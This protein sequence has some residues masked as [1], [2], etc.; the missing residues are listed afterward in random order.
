MSRKFAMDCL[1][2]HQTW[3]D[4]RGEL[5]YKHSCQEVPLYCSAKIVVY[6]LSQILFDRLGLQRIKIR[7]MPL[8]K[9]M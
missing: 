5:Y 4:H 6:F 3:C 9:N 8:K 2:E 7:L 1:T